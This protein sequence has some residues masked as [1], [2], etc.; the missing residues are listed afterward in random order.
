MRS[1]RSIDSHS[2]S[3][4][5]RAMYAVARDY[6]DIGYTVATCKIKA[7]AQTHKKELMFV[8]AW[9]GATRSNCL[10]DF[11]DDSHNGLVIVTGHHSDLIV[12]DCDRKDPSK[13]GVNKWNELIAKHGAVPSAPVVKSASGG[14]HIYFSMAK[15]LANGLKNA[16]N[17]TGLSIEGHEY[18]IDVRGEGG[19]VIAPPSEYERGRYTWQRPLCNRDEL[20]PCPPWLIDELNKGHVPRS[21]R[22]AITNS[23]EQVSV[24]HGTYQQAE[25]DDQ[26]PVVHRIKSYLGMT[27]DTSSVY[28]H[29]LRSGTDMLHVF[30]VQGP[31][32]CPYGVAHRGSNNFSVIQRS[33]DLLYRCHGTECSGKVPKLMSSLPFDEMIR[34]SVAFPVDARD[35]TVYDGLD[36]K[37]TSQK[38][39]EADRGGAELF[40]KMYATSQRIV[41]SEREFYIWNGKLW[42]KDDEGKKVATVMSHQLQGAFIR[43]NARLKQAIHDETDEEEK[44][45]LLMLEVE[46]PQNWTKASSVKQP[47]IFLKDCLFNQDFCKLLGSNKDVICVDNGVIDLKSGEL[48]AHHPKFFCHTSLPTFWKGLDF[49]T[50]DIDAFMLDIFNED[51][52]AIAYLQRLLGYGISGHTREEVFAIFWGQG[53][54]GK[55]ILN[56]MLQ[57]LLGD[58]YVTMSKDCIIKNDRGTSKAAASPHMAELRQKRIAV[59]DESEDQEKLDDGSIKM[60]TGGSDINCRFL[61][62]NPISFTPT[63]LPILMT[64][65]KPTIDTD[66]KAVL[67]RLILVPFPNQYKTPE[68]FDPTNPTHRPRD[69]TLKERLSTDQ[70]KEQLL[71]WLVKGSI[72]WYR[73][74]SLGCKPELFNAAIKEY[75]IENDLLG[76]FITDFCV[77]KRSGHV[78]TKQ[79][80][81]Q[82]ESAMEVSVSSQALVKSMRNRGFIKK[83]IMIDGVRGMYFAGIEFKE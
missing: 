74:G 3:S 58:Y 23:D 78:E 34:N 15:S 25:A 71:V 18:D 1:P 31:R 57:A 61:Y 45:R 54:N 64:N 55:G 27:G 36:L 7:N 19:I 76:Q 20:P 67:R 60:A 68:E 2:V 43:F 12:V 56:Q 52:E 37:Y 44:R 66:D 22:L 21:N 47:M 53:G 75:M 35:Q 42:S 13:D 59:C 17:R 10:E 14:L 79:F 65:H 81:L 41:Y 8:R 28:T 51:R 38:L 63:H 11:I 33:G 5:C 83:Q 24:A 26:G 9:H 69:N 77:K 82:Y 16:R 39:K 50:P 46:K 4:A 72:D 32:V 30:R 49:P 48:S 29:T 6:H 73:V 62:G 80:R 40:A 70:V